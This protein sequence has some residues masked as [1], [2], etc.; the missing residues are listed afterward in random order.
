MDY[1]SDDPSSKTRFPTSFNIHKEQVFNW[2]DYQRHHCYPLED[3]V[4]TWPSKPAHYREVSSLHCTEVMAFD[5]RL[6]AGGNNGEQSSRKARSTHGYKLLSQGPQSWT[7][8]RSTSPFRSQC[9][10]SSTRGWGARLTSAQQWTLDCCHPIP[11][12]FVELYSTSVIN[13]RLY[14]CACHS[15]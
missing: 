12:S 14:E 3:H 4:H 5:V 2:R 11:N 10:H 9:A 8:I 13:Y 7:Y 6:L 1:Y 15:N